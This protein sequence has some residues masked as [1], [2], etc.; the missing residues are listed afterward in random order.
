MNVDATFQVSKG[1]STLK[2]GVNRP[3]SMADPGDTRD[4]RPSQSIF[5]S[6]SCSFRKKI[7]PN[8]RLTPPPPAVEVG[9]LL[10]ATPDAKALADPRGH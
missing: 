1:E 6:F 10:V 4:V 3:L 2:L 5:F 7:M 8:N 9:A